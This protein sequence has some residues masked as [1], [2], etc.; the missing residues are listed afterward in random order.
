MWCKFPRLEYK[1]IFQLFNYLSNIY[2]FVSKKK[3][4]AH[5]ILQVRFMT[6]PGLR[7]SANESSKICENFVIVAECTQRS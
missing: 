5:F 3:P 6:L 1:N 2:I 4:Q 7:K